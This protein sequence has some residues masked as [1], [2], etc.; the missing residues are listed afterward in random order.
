MSVSIAAL[1]LMVIAS[2]GQDDQIQ[3]LQKLVHELREDVAELKNQKNET[4]LNQQRAK[5]IRS[6]VLEVLSDADTRA[7]MRGNGVLAGYDGG[8]YLMSLDENWKLKINGQLQARWLYNNA[9]RQTSQR[10]FE[11]RRTKV[12]FSGHIFD[13]SWTYKIATT[14]GRG[15]G[16]NTED[17]WIA[18]KF[19]NGQWIRAGQ[20]KAWFLRENIISSSKQLAVNSSMVNNAFT[21]GWVQG[22]STGWNNDDLNL[23]VQYTDGPW[24]FNTAALGASTNAWIAR[25]EF[26]FGE[27][28]WNDFAYLTSKLGAMDGLL[29]GVAYENYNTDTAG[30]FEYGNAN[31]DESY[32][33]TIDASLRGDGW[34][35]FGY[36]VET[37][38]KDT[39][40]GF[41]QD[42]SGWLIQ[43]G[44]MVNNNYELF[45]Q[46]QNGEVNDAVFATGSSEMSAFRIGINYWPIM[47]SNHLKWTTDVAWSHDSL[48]DGGAV[49]GNGSADWTGTGNGWR[50]DILNGDGQMLVRTQVQLVF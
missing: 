28:G 7:S 13:P 45:V 18:K 3:T 29:I 23:F 37:T 22:V 16:S 30:G 38:G 33:W 40:T 39:V 21:Y 35:L 9:D 48:A 14:W 24:S 50:Q 26:K 10:G 6:L 47:G 25:A 34:N 11:M 36:V 42:S 17:A 27:A 20:F 8:A 41:E 12:I 44:F 46:Y 2:P 1:I 31:A 43:G 32:G 19:D 49:A 4:W 5:E 15:G